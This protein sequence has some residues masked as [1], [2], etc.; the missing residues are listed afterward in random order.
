MIFLVALFSFL[1]VPSIAIAWGPTTHLYLGQKLLAGGAG[2]I[3]SAIYACIT[4]FPKDFL[5]GTIIADIVVGKK[6]QE[7]GGYSHS[8]KFSGELFRLARSKAHNAFAYG[9]QAHLAADTVA[10][11][12]YIPRFITMPNLTHAMLE[13]KADSLIKKRLLIK[14]DSVVQIRNDLLLERALERAKL[15]FKTNKRLFK[16][17]LSLSRLPYSKPVSSFINRHLLYHVPEEEIR[18]YQL[19]SYRKM[20]ECFSEEKKANVHKIDP[21]G[22]R[23]RGRSAAF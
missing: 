11:N 8:W 21:L 13:M 14:T 18:H 3:P 9:Y 20:L 12:E 5:Y 1:A 23:T 6:F 19:K 16:G 10:H 17:M 2:V 4:A 7:P 22:R 15:S